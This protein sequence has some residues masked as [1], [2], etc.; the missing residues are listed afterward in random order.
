MAVGYTFGGI[1]CA[2]ALAMGIHNHY[3]GTEK[4]SSVLAAENAI[5]EWHSLCRGGDSKPLLKEILRGLEVIEPDGLTTLAVRDS[6]EIKSCYAGK[7]LADNAGEVISG[8]SVR[9]PWK[10]NPSVYVTAG[11]IMIFGAFCIGVNIYANKIQPEIKQT[12][13]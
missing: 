2:G 9:M 4:S 7:I 12:K 5:R 11:M 13:S 3:S 8:A 1:L 6:L 10:D